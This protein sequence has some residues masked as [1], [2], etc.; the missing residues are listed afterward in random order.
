MFKPSYQR[1][2]SLLGAT[3][4]FG[5]FGITT[6]WLLFL[7]QNGLS[8]LQ[9]GLLESLFHA[10][11]FLSEVPSGVLADRFSYKTNLY[12]SRVATILSAI[13][14]LAGHGNIWIYALGMIVNAWAYN[15]DSGTSAAMLFESAKEAG[16][17]DKYLRYSSIISALSEGTRTLGMVV[18]GFFIH[19]FLDVTY[20]ISIVFSLLVCLFIFLMKEPT[21]KLQTEE[22]TTV[23]SIL[24]A[25]KQS[26]HEN[27][28]LLATMFFT[29]TAITLISMFYFYY[30]NEISAFSS[31]QISFIMLISSGIN[32]LAIWLAGRLGEGIQNQR[33]L[34]FILAITTLLFALAYLGNPWIYTLIY[35]IAEA[36][37]AFYLP[38]FGNSLQHQISSEIR[39]TMLSVNAMLGSLSMIFI[40]PAVGWMIDTFHFA[41]AFVLLAGVLVFFTIFFAKWQSS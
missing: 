5:F 18:A 15:F 19:G 12:L 40:F 16:H 20:Y 14:M 41:T 26:F 28:R 29:Q 27:P 38:I 1:N 36:L 10:T 4:F 37:V 31:W 3:E 2:I 32:I 13:L 30:Q 24:T 17:E 8:L 25:V 33:L 9:I 34:V 35:L 21:T 6:F 23:K 11:S 7:S 39:A 22:R